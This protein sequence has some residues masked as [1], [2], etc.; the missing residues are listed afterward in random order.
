MLAS[1]DSS[2]TTPGPSIPPSDMARW[3]ARLGGG[4]LASIG[5]IAMLAKVTFLQALGFGFPALLAGIVMLVLSD[6]VWRRKPAAALACAGIWL[7]H[8]GWVL[9]RVIESG[10]DPSIGL[11]I[12][13][14]ILTAVMVT[15]AVAA[16]RDQRRE[17]IR[18]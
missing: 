3:A 9:V 12:T 6:S 17:P 10:G 13:R 16:R 11:W 4:S 8:G 18:G 2:T 5:F 15:P 1:H 14:L 7:L